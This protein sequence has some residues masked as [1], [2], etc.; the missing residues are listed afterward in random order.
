MLAPLKGM[1]L[2]LVMISSMSVLICNYFHT[3]Q[4]KS[5]T[6]ISRSCAQ[7]S[8]NLGG[9]DLKVLLKSTSNA[10]NFMCRLS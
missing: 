5:D 3:I 4:H 1:S 8:M 2:V 10:E 6:A 7:A 9:K